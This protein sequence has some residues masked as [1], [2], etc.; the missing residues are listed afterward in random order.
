MN[1]MRKM[2]SII[3]DVEDRHFMG[4]ILA[5]A[6]SFSCFMPRMKSCRRTI[7]VEG[8]AALSHGTINGYI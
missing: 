1:K 2:R 7:T 5:L 8:S 6:F 4:L 3:I